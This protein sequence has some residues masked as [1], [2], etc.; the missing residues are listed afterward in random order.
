MSCS[1]GSAFLLHVLT[2]LKPGLVTSCSSL[3]PSCYVLP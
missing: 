3:L 1:D 2:M